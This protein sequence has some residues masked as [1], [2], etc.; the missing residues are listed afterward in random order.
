M[1]SCRFASL[2]TDTHSRGFLEVGA[3]P[4]EF[5]QAVPYSWNL[6]FHMLAFIKI[7]VEEVGVGR[8]EEGDNMFLLALV[9][10]VPAL[11]A[12]GAGMQRKPARCLVHMEQPEGKEWGTA[13][14]A[15]ALPSVL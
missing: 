12:C 15:L 1:G 14:K 5:Q 9:L 10:H 11:S 7:L 8:S 4:V 6:L 3:W 2:D 13:A